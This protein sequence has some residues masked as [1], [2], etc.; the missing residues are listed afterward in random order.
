MPKNTERSD[1]KDRA[2]QAE[3][4]VDEPVRGRETVSMFQKLE[5]SL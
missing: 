2:V 4:A 1:V 3:G 5:G